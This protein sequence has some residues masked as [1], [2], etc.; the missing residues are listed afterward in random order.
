MLSSSTRDITLFLGGVL[1][2]WAGPAIKRPRVPL[3]VVT[4]RVTTAGK[5]FT[6]F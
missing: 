3:A 5:L 1:A 2:Q 4:Q 6:R